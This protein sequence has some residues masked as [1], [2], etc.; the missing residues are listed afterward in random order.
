[1]YDCLVSLKVVEGKV[2]ASTEAV[3]KSAGIGSMDSLREDG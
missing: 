3:S 2:R 1:M